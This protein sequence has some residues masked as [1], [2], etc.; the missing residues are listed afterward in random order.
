VFELKGG[1]AV[2]SNFR[3]FYHRNSDN[4][5]LK[6]AGDFDG[7]SATEL[8]NVIKEK[9]CGASKVII[10]TSSLRNIHPFGLNTFRQNFGDII[11]LSICI[12]FTG[13]YACQM[14]PEKGLCL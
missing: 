13:E 6:L 14:S 10:H 4:L 12:L 1:Q 7:S 3:I 5:H 2:A 8:V 9:R 11:N